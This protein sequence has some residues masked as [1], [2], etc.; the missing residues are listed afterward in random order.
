MKTRH[1]IFLITCAS[2]LTL[3]TSYGMNTDLGKEQGLSLTLGQNITTL[4]PIA[5][6]YYV[7]FYLVDKT[8]KKQRNALQHN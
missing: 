2:W 7:G 8:K 3:L 5:I 4:L 1:I 6:V